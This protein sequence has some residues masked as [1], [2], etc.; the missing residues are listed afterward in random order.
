MTGHYSLH[1]N[2]SLDRPALST[3]HFCLIAFV[4][5]PCVSKLTL[6]PFKVFSYS[7]TSLHEIFLQSYF[8]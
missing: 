4:T 2:F 6:T 8:F 1:I 3:L 5:S 7:I